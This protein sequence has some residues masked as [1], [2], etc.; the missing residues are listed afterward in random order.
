MQNIQTFEWRTSAPPCSMAVAET[1]RT[2]PRASPF[3]LPPRSPWPLASMHNS[4][5]LFP[6]LFPAAHTRKGRV[7]PQVVPCVC[8]RASRGP[9][10]WLPRPLP[11]S[12]TVLRRG[13]RTSPAETPVAGES[14]DLHRRGG[15]SR[16]RRPCRAPGPRGAV[17]APGRPVARLGCLDAPT[18]YTLLRGGPRQSPPA[19]SPASSLLPGLRRCV[20]CGVAD[21]P[22]H[23]AVPGARQRARAHPPFCSSRPHAVYIPEPCSQVPHVRVSIVAHTTWADNEWCVWRR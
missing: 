20:V 1:H 22:S 16:C 11:L 21:T 2:V 14:C 19:S 6:P 10:P 3:L 5:F 9:P 7:C 15:A 18:R 8:I 17:G 13:L 12:P 23:L 4:L